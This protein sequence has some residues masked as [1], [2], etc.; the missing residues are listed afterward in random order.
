MKV[1]DLEWLHRA[2]DTI[3]WLRSVGSGVF[4]DN[5]EHQAYRAALERLKDHGFDVDDFFIMPEEFSDEG[6]VYRADFARRASLA[7]GYIA[8]RLAT[9]GTVDNSQP[10][11][12]E[13][14]P[15]L[16]NSVFVIH[17]QDTDSVE[18]IF[19]LLR[20][21]ELLPRDFSDARRLSSNPLP[22]VGEVL[23]TA[24]AHAEAVLA[25]FTPDERV[26]LR[27]ALRGTQP[28]AVEFQPR[29]N[30]LIEAGTALA[31]HPTRTVIAELGEVRS[32]SDLSGR[33]VVRWREDTPAARME[34]L[35]RLRDAGCIPNMSGT[36]WMDAG[37]KKRPSWL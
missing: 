14:G 28:I 35:D 18:T 31:T 8:R 3:E 19:A 1:E 33:H 17:G 6:R 26:E 24:F 36:R 5:S 10:A 25:L 13:V 9:L 2:N 34:L 20:E 11:A 23:A 37:R 30:V 16:A 7:S 4:L 22:Y 21:V 29:P 15:A 27:D 12:I 32:I